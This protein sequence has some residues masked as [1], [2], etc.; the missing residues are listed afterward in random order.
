MDSLKNPPQTFLY[1]AVSATLSTSGWDWVTPESSG[2]EDQE[3]VFCPK[4]TEAQFY[5]VWSES[6][7]QSWDKFLPNVSTIFY[8]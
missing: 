6:Q 2:Y 4:D 7:D 1:G 3:V 8:F 5:G